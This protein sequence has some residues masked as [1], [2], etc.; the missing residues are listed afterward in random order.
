M[1]LSQVFEFSFSIWITL[2]LAHVQKVINMYHKNEIP[3]LPHRTQSHALLSYSSHLYKYQRAS[4]VHRDQPDS[5][6][7]KTVCAARA[8]CSQLF[9]V[10]FQVRMHE[11]FG[12]LLA[13]A[14]VVAGCIVAVAICRI[15]HCLRPR[16]F[17]YIN[18]IRQPANIIHLFR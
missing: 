18:L 13:V 5:C 12:C 1:I 10:S 6:S 2:F 11:N 17:N 3:M 14:V 15:A 8:R 16:V 9:L 4:S 7:E